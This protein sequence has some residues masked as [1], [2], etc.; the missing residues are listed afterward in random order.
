MHFTSVVELCVVSL[1]AALN[2]DWPHNPDTKTLS[3]SSFCSCNRQQTSLL[4]MTSFQL[5]ESSLGNVFQ[6]FWNVAL[7]ACTSRS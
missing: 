5:E 2:T 1:E 3:P 7:A 6:E 4:A